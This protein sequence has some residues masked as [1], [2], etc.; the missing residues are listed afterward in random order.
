LTAPFARLLACDLIEDALPA[1][2][3][4]DEEDVET[5]KLEQPEDGSEPTEQQTE[6][7]PARAPETRVL[8]GVGAGPREARNAITGDLSKVAGYDVESMVELGGLEPPTSWVRSR[9]SPI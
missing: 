8:A 1:P 7:E 2:V 3:P 6:D 4:A 9:R 5:N